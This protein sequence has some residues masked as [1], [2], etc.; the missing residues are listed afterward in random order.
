MAVAIRAPRGGMKIDQDPNTVAAAVFDEMLYCIPG[1]GI[2]LSGFAFKHSSHAEYGA[3]REESYGQ[4]NRIAS[5]DVSEP[6]EIIL[7]ESREPM[8][9]PF[10][11]GFIES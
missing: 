3:K 8:G 6:A 9:F 2:Y 1:V 7:I 11:S 5:R 4:A 10:S